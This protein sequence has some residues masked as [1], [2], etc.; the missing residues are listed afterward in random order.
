MSA[1]NPVRLGLVGAGYIARIHAEAAAAVPS[2][3]EIVAAADANP[4]AAAGLAE[5]FRWG[6]SY[7]DVAEMLR[8]EDLDG[9][10][11][12]TWPSTHL[13]LIRQCIDAGVRHVLCEK[14][15]LMNGSEALEAW[16][17]VNES[18][19]TLTEAF[20]YR[21]HPALHR[22]DDI[23]AARQLGDIDHVRAS[24]TYLNRPALLGI[25]PNDPNRPWRFQ[26]DQGGGALYDIGAYAVN[27]CTHVAAA[28]PTRVASFGRARNDFG[29]SDKVIGLIDYANGVVGMVEASEVCDSSQEL[30]ISGE[31]GTLY[32]PFTWT[33]YG[34]SHISI[35]RSIDS[36]HR[37]P[38]RS[39]RTLED[40]LAVPASSAF[41][42]QLVNVAES[43]WGVASPRVSLAETVIN[44]ITIEALTRSL[45]ERDEVE[46]SVP[47]DVAAAFTASP[48]AVARA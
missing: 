7:G 44:T 23:L 41:Q 8:S 46:V 2:H 45:R 24:F 14:P 26:A 13:Q 47:D 16:S 43:I 11:I 38:A 6:K 37:D 29:T 22:V 12:A 3:V 20:M 1:F 34:D 33:I 40:S 30:Q 39:F 35:R 31:L 9:V 27:A 17:L 21:H 28:I 15:L 25:D 48:M 42:D 19:A 10:I 5:R 4:G 18:G 36:A 32:L